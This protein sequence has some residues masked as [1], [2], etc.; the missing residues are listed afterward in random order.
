MGFVLRIWLGIKEKCRK[1]SRIISFFNVFAPL[2]DNDDSFVK[3]LRAWLA[4]WENQI[5]NQSWLV[6]SK[7]ARCCGNG[8]VWWSLENLF[9]SLKA[10]AKRYIEVNKI[11]LW[12]HTMELETSKITTNS[13][14]IKHKEKSLCYSDKIVR[15]RTQVAASKQN[16]N[17]STN[18]S[19][20]SLMSTRNWTQ[21]KDDKS[22]KID[23]QTVWV[24]LSKFKPELVIEL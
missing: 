3:P 7:L 9:R 24:L 8:I 12:S 4:P 6:D 15:D 2:A 14:V 21:K 17:C 22:F 10:N 5:S 20:N 13:W 19:K 1:I 11:T 16:Y 23:L 18:L